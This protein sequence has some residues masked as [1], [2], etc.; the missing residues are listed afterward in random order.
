MTAGSSLVLNIPEKSKILLRANNCIGDD[1]ISNPAQHMLRAAFPRASISILA[2][3][4]VAPVLNNNPDIDEILLYEVPGRHKGLPGIW[5]LAHD[6]RGR[7]FQAAILFQ[8]AFEAALICFLARIPY[9]AGFRTDGRSLLLTHGLRVTEEDF[10]VHR[11][12]HNLRMLKALGLPPSAKEL[13][14]HVD[15]Q[16]IERSKAIL[17]S[18]GIGLNDFLIGM[19]PGATF[20]TAK[21]WLPERFTALADRLSSS[22]GA[23]VLIFGSAGEQALGDEICRRSSFSSLFNLA[24]ATSLEEAL[25]LIGLCGLFVTNDSGLMHVA[26]ALDIPMTA[27]FGPTEPRQTSPYYKKHRLLR[28]EDIDCSPCMDR[29]CKK[30]H[31]CM[32]AISVEEVF[33][34]LEEL[35]QLYGRPTIEARIQSLP[36]SGKRVPQLSFGD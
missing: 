16:V 22:L 35:L 2:K 6:L 19:N 34:S 10:M 24:G 12:E 4:W 3:P 28:R 30:E 21:R 36:Y 14:L 18:A 5:R 15:P 1:I 7:D 23:K 8:R 31:Q 17:A 11:V 20:G 33:H 25:A 13:V 32:T 9:R 26:A 27:I 29:E